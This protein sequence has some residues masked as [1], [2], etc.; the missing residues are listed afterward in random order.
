M[1]FFR[2]IQDKILG[3]FPNTPLYNS[4]E[5]YMALLGLSIIAG[6]TL[7]WLRFAIRNYVRPRKNLIERYGRGTWD[8][9]TG[10]TEGIGKGFAIRFGQLGFNV[11]IVARNQEK[12]DN[13]VKEIKASAP[14][15]V[16]VKTVKADFVNCYQEKF[17]D[18]IYDQLKDLDISILINN[19]G[20]S[21]ENYFH[22]FSSQDMV[23]FFGVNCVSQVMMTKKIL[24][25][26]LYRKNKSAIISISSISGT[27][28]I[29]YLQPYAATKAFNDFFSKALTEEYGNKL[30]I[31][32]M[33]PHF[34]RTA[35]TFNKRI[36]GWF[37]IEVEQ[38]VESTLDKL[39]YETHSAGHPK[40]QLAMI[41]SECFTEDQKIR[42]QRKNMPRL[43]NMLLELKGN[44]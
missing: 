22:S 21:G 34:I 23:D 41:L 24:P 37:N 35:M 12:M 27:S 10:A 40:H 13:V 17:F 25:N 42:N 9:I 15:T 7:F 38:F 29:G 16:E 3:L 2:K 4:I 28:F 39:G 1:S 44:K 14:D 18:D 26:M 11:A 33:T 30:D 6:R 20:L 43:L 32:S 8:V 36:G 19:V 31:L 5:K